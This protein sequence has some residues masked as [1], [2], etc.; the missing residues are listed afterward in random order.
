MK[1]RPETDWTH[2]GQQNAE[3][4]RRKGAGGFLELRE[5]VLAEHCRKWTHGS[6]VE[7]GR[8]QRDK[9]PGPSS[10][11][12]ARRRRSQDASEKFAVT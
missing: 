12:Q 9:T 4:K 10:R 7:A 6:G 11:G 1:N 8:H 5:S 2:A 3:T